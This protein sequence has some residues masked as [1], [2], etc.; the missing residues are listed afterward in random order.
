MERIDVAKLLKECPSGMKLDSTMYENIVFDKII[1]DDKIFPIRVIREE[2]G[3]RISLTKYGQYT[4]IGSSKCIIFPEGKTSWEGFVPPCKFKDGDIIF[5]HTNALKFNLDNYWVSIFKEYRNNR[6]AC[7]VCVCLSDLDLYHDKWE[8]ELLCELCEIEENRLATKEEK[9][10]LFKAIK[11]NGY[12]WNAETKTLEKLT[13]L[14]ES[15]EEVDDEIVMSGIY[16]D[17]EYYADEVELHLNNY[18]IEIRNGKTYAIFKNQETKISKPI[19]KVDDKVKLKGGDEFGI[20]TQVSDCFF[21]IKC[22]NNTHCWPIKKQ[23]DWEL[24]KEPKFKIGDKIRKKDG[25]DYRLRT[26]ESINNN[27]YIIKT[28]DWFDNCYI[29]DKLPFNCQDEYELIYNKKFDINTMK[30]FESRVLVRDTDHYEWEGAIFG[31]YDGNTF[32]TI[33]G[34][35]WKYCIPYE[36]NEHLL[37]KTDDCDDFFKI[38][39]S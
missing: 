39:E 31:R 9:E 2:D 4:N 34:V 20:I 5:T 12:K 38:W 17:R 27:Y 7:Y 35:D 11:D 14:T 10:K 24:V 33:G 23:D 18:E 30:P 22:K 15:K 19:F 26:I 32:F 29:T 3:L 16:F 6:C 21:T 37:G 28:P 36:G 8:D 1:E 13:E 25:S